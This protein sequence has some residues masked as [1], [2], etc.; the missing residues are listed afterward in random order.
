MNKKKVWQMKE[1]LFLN[2]S[3][4]NTVREPKTYAIPPSYGIFIK[5][6]VTVTPVPVLCSKLRSL[7]HAMSQDRQHGCNFCNDYNIT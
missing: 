2:R 7:G 3:Q 6:V 5:S 4:K 1:N